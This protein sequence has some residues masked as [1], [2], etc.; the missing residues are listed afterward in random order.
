VCEGAGGDIH[1]VQHDLHRAMRVPQAVMTAWSATPLCPHAGGGAKL[2]LYSIRRLRI[3]SDFS[4]LA[5]G[6]NGCRSLKKTSFSAPCTCTCT[7]S[8]FP[9]TLQVYI[10]KYH[11]IFLDISSLCFR[12]VLSI[13]VY[14]E[15]F[16]MDCSMLAERMTNWPTRWR[17]VA[18][19]TVY[20]NTVA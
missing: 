17:S 15:A 13:A 14:I 7:L 8:P 4:I 16:D 9:P 11:T 1:G 10:G 18:L 19:R 3:P 6:K 2:L 20:R 12:I 5:S